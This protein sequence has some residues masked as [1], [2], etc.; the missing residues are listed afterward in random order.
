MPDQFEMHPH[1]PGEARA[2]ARSFDYQGAQAMGEQGQKRAD[3]INYMQNELQKMTP[4]ERKLFYGTYDD[5]NASKGSPVYANGYIG[6]SPD[7]S[8]PFGT[9]EKDNDG[10]PT[11][12]VFNAPAMA[13]L[14]SS[15]TGKK[16]DEIVVKPGK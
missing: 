8:Q 5:A 11:G 12:I 14:W 1:T 4:D 6:L 7:S 15:F 16:A 3:A 9:V 13:S 2:D 10:S